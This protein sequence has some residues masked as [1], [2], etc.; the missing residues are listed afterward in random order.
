MKTIFE[1][2]NT[3]TTSLIKKYHPTYQST[4]TNTNA[5]NNTNHNIS[6]GIGNFNNHN[7]NNTAQHRSTKTVIDYIN[8][9]H[10][11]QMAD[12]QRRA[13]AMIHDNQSN[14]LYVVASPSAGKTLTVECFWA[15]HMLGIINNN[16]PDVVEQRLLELI[17]KPEL[18]DT[19][20]FTGPVRVLVNGIYSDFIILMTEIFI[21]YVT[22]LLKELSI[23]NFVNLISVFTKFNSIS[24]NPNEYKL[25]QQLTMLK[26][27]LDQIIRTP[28]HSI[29]DMYHDIEVF[30]TDNVKQISES[31]KTYASTLIGVKTAVNSS[32]N[33]DTALV[34]TA[35]YESSLSLYN[36]K[37]TKLIV[38]DEAHLLQ[39]LAGNS[40]RA[41]QIATVIY[42][43]LSKVNKQQT[44]VLFLSGTVNPK[45]A[46]S[47]IHIMSSC[48]GLKI[49]ISNEHPAGNP[50]E[51]MIVE[52]EKLLSS[53][54]IYQL[55]S[56]PMSSNNVILIFN[57]RKIFGLLT[58]LI[59]KNTPLS[60]RDIENGVLATSNHKLSARVNRLEQQQSP[61]D[62]FLDNVK[63]NIKT[64]YHVNDITHTIQRL[65]VLRGVGFIVNLDYQANGDRA[66]KLA[67]AKDQEIVA[68]LFKSG[69]IH[70]ILTTDSIGIGVNI[71]VKNMYIPAMEKFSG[72]GVAPLPIS[73]G[74]QVLNRTGRRSFKVGTI[75]TP[76]VFIPDVIT[77]LAA[78][79]D[80][81][82][83]RITII[84]KF[85]HWTANIFAS[86]FNSL[87]GI[88]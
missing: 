44:K 6:T 80:E 57:K 10:C 49:A 48:F 83:E 3:S 39:E 15:T 46:K 40:D 87:R 17:F 45:S 34:T 7:N 14:G 11:K 82:E 36:P 21:G 81:F 28:T 8:V 74:S 55:I 2:F 20:L 78:S 29:H 13:V 65:S 62:Q 23:D 72:T 70:T 1:A 16:N 58:Q 86:L 25:L 64:K 42:K 88:S 75:Q 41:Q 68:A 12:W 9:S 61:V 47:L 52:N 84:P 69:L 43:L 85:H 71:S 31:C 59:A 32:G 38:I 67:Y 19:L 54:Y 18:L 5:P 56:K 33:Y 77:A 26:I 50:A 79:N 63:D 60:P 22:Y 27:K 4:N 51:L 53:Q 73:D 37:R 35:I 24:H 30:L 76:A 66:L